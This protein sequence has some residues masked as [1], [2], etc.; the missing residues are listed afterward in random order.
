M[1]TTVKIDNIKVKRS[2]GIIKSRVS[3][4]RMRNF[5]SYEKLRMNDVKSD[6]LCF[7]LSYFYLPFVH[8]CI[9]AISPSLPY[10]LFFFLR[11]ES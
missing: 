8:G 6:S 3:N 1:V 10:L 5:C 7:V 9:R 2:G 4:A 11:V